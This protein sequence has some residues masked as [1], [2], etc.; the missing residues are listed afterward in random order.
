MLSFCLPFRR[1]HT[2]THI[3]LAN[4]NRNKSAEKWR[5]KN[6]EMCTCGIIDVFAYK[7]LHT[8]AIKWNGKTRKIINM[9]KSESS[10]F[11]ISM[12][13]EAID[14]RARFMHFCLLFGIVR[15]CIMTTTNPKYL[16]LINWNWL[17]FVLYGWF[18]ANRFEIHKHAATSSDESANVFA[19]CLCSKRPS[20]L[21][22]WWKATKCK[23]RKRIN[24]YATHFKCTSMFHA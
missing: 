15:Q 13:N 11:P 17:P 10:E 14:T 8:I 4:S 24:E 7:I 22:C 2:S 18:N 9:K 6:C 16:S 1:V 12:E 23:R 5:E 21:I 3:H 20:K 19:V